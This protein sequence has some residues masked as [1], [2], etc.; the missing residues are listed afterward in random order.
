VSKTGQLPS[1][2][3]WRAVGII[4]VLGSHCVFTNGFP[5]KYCSFVSN[6]FDGI[7]G[8]RF[9]FTI[10]GFLITWLMLKEE[11]EAGYM[12]LKYF[13]VRRAFRILPV[14]LACIIVMAFFQLTGLSVQKG[15][16]WL[17][18][19]T[20]T[21]NFHQTGHPEYLVSTHVWSLSVEEQFYFIWPVVFLMLG[22]SP[23]KRIGFLVVVIIFSLIFKIVA[24]L[25]CY[26]RHLF[27][28][29]QENSTFLYLDCISYGCIGAILLDTK[30]R[31]LKFFFEK[32]S[33]WIFALSGLL[34]LG[35]EIVGLGI[36]LQSFAFIFL[37]MQS[38]LVP[39]FRPFKILNNRWLVSV[40]I[41]S[42]SLYIWQQLIFVL[43]PIPKLWFMAL[44]S[45]FVAAWMSYNFLE[46]PFF[47]IRSKF[48]AHARQ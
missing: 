32:F 37:L 21:R 22:R 20:F 47:S 6:I 34:L 1:L 9:F 23:R 30:A 2:N 12:N 11:R 16:V 24:L 28:L 45:A 26:N 38:I 13:Y 17:Q 4:L 8:V 10:S 43:W 46:R 41:I 3:G 18:L 36:G 14:Y 25:G 15:F 33:L 40:G 7:L 48:R 19:F 42:Y 31:S 44:P 27:F 35:P 29:F 5:S 39:E